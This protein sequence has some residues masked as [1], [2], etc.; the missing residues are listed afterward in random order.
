MNFDDSK[1]DAAFRREVYTWLEANAK[2]RAPGELPAGIAEREDPVQIKAARDWQAKK[3]DAGW[4]CIGWPREYGGRGGSPTENYIWQQEEAKFRVP[5]AIFTIGISMAGPTIMR[6]GTEAQ[7]SCWL[8]ACARGDD[9]WCQLFSEPSAGSDLASLRTRAVKEGD[10][11]VVNGQKIWTSG[12]HYA[13]WGILLARTDF[14]VPKHAGLTFFVVD[15]KSA[16]IEVRR[17]HQITDNAHFNEVYFTDMRIPDSNRIS[18][19]GGGWAVAMTT[20]TMER[21]GVNL[22]STGG[23]SVDDLLDLASRVY[24]DGEPAINNEGI[25]EEIAGYIVKTYALRFTSFRN[26]TALSRGESLGPRSAITK[27]VLGKLRQNMGALG[28]ELQGAAGSL[29]DI[30]ETYKDAGWQFAYLYAPGI[31]VAGG[32]DEIMR[33][34]IATGRSASS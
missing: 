34:P 2:L 19:V 20:L 6:H 7:K 25:R 9:I 17:I 1:E 8:P 33:N 30:D 26:M 3:L 16:G 31:R 5:P 12:A 24:Q 28:L 13:D 10:E 11:W 23:V 29:N 18:D 22:D 14:D 32:T 4:A 27:L 15:M 21:G